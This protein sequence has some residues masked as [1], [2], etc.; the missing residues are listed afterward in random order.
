MKWAVVFTQRSSKKKNPCFHFLYFPSGQVLRRPCLHLAFTCDL[1]LDMFSDKYHLIYAS[2]HL[3]LL[4]SE[5]SRSRQ[6]DAEEKDASTGL[7]CFC[8]L[9]LQQQHSSL[10]SMAWNQSIKQKI[11]I[12][13]EEQIG[14][15]TPRLEEEVVETI[16][17]P[18]S[19]LT[20]LNL[21]YIPIDKVWYLLKHPAS[22]VHQ[23]EVTTTTTQY[24]ASLRV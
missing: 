7:K 4:R 9:T 3:Q 18:S 2:L 12:T 17:D 20:S 11:R 21:K 14:A 24:A 19:T 23:E 13:W 15:S 16:E 8:F 10:R 6:R 1:Y 5:W 22:S